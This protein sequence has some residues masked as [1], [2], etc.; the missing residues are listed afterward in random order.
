MPLGEGN[1][2]VHLLGA[3][4]RRCARCVGADADTVAAF[5]VCENFLDDSRIF[6][7]GYDTDCPTAMLASLYVDKV[8]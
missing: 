4:D 1:R 5:D 2:S 8:N 7:T 6:D 3:I